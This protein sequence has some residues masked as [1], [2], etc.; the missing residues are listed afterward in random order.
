MRL[1][2]QRLTNPFSHGSL[3]Q[4]RGRIDWKSVPVIM[5]NPS[6]LFKGPKNQRREG[7]RAPQRQDRT[8][9]ILTAAP[10]KQ[11]QLRDKTF[12]FL[13]VFRD[14]TSMKATDPL[15]VDSQCLTAIQ[16]PPLPCN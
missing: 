3:T 12:A 7:D 16:A 11:S 9:N 6:F 13:S 5:C 15:S 2:E 1:K 8:N 4:V 14:S 10:T